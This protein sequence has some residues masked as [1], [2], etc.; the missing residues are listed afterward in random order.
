LLEARLVNGHFPCRQPVNLFLINI[1]A[2]YVDTEFG[3]TRTC[4][5]ADIT[6]ADYRYVH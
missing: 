1:D 3:E 4:H 5:K 6:R 2:S